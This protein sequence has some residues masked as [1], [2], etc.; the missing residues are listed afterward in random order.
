MLLGGHLLGQQLK[1][2]EKLLI[3]P[4]IVINAEATKHIATR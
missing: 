3:F 4:F 2:Q 1:Y